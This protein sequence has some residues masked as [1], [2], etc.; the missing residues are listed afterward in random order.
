MENQ[1]QPQRIH[2]NHCPIVSIRLLALLANGNVACSSNEDE[3]GTIQIWNLEK[4]EMVHSL[5]HHTDRVVGLVELSNRHLASNS[6]DNRV[7]V[8][9]VESGQL[10]NTFEIEFSPYFGM[11]AL[12]EERFAC[13]EKGR[14][15]V[16][17]IY[18]SN[19]GKR[20]NLLQ[21]HQD[22]VLN[23]ELL[24]DDYIASSSVDGEIKVWD[25]NT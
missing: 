9:S 16:I 12:P 23:L 7:K 6:N 1:Q 11:K 25:L 17:S 18:A 20:L 19:T 14:K 21:V 24:D 4:E 15:G 22:W 5:C 8:W 2:N 10:L 13:A 3:D